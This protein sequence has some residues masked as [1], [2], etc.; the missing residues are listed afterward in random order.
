MR[1]VPG[2]DKMEQEP[3]GAY[4]FGKARYRDNREPSTRGLPLGAYQFG[5]CWCGEPAAH[6]WPGRSKGAPHPDLEPDDQ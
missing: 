3:E 4:Q 5:A 1:S 2:L 6:D